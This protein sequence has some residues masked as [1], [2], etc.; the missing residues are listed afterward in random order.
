MPR[1]TQTS[2]IFKYLS[3]IVL[4]I[5]IIL[6]IYLWRIGAFTNINVLRQIVGIDRHPLLAPIIFFALQIFQ[7]LIPVIPG[8]IT[9]TAGVVLFGPWLGFIYNYLSIVLGSILAFLVVRYFGQHFIQ[10]YI[11]AEKH[12]K[13]L[14]WLEDEKKFTRLF[15]IAILLPGAPD[16]ILS[17]LAGLS[18][19]KIRT[20][21]IIMLIAKIPSI[22]V[23]SGGFSFLKQWFHF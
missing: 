8:T 18:T 10:H 7:I 13:Y 15:A 4:V 9:L 2:K 17:M 5:I 6:S 12:G 16:D 11:D 19:M 1:S 20:F 23:Y 3:Y 14:R 22:A 21:I